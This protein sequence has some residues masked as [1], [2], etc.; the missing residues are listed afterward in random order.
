MAVAVDFRPEAR[1][2]FAAAGA[3]A[4]ASGAGI[5]T[6]AGTGTAAGASATFATGTEA[7]SGV[8]RRCHRWVI[9]P[10]TI[11]GIAETAT[12][13]GHDTWKTWALA[14]CETA[15]PA[16]EVAMAPMALPLAHR[17]ALRPA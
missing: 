7:G 6:G 3:E 13:I 15:L 14:A 1:T 17:R 12:T 9:R 10:S 11:E 16:T 4:S 8:L 2:G 5:T